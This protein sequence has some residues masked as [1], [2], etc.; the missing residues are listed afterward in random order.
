MIIII[1]LGLGLLAGYIL[2]LREMETIMHLAI[3]LAVVSGISSIV[4]FVMAGT[5]PWLS[6]KQKRA[7]EEATKKDQE[8]KKINESRKEEAI[9]RMRK[10]N[11]KRADELYKNQVLPLE[12]ERES[13]RRNLASMD[14][15]SSDDM[16]L[17]TVDYLIKQ[18][19][20]R[21][22]NSLTEALHQYDAK[23]DQEERDR[24]QR[25]KEWM[26]YENERLQRQLDQQ[27]A[28][29][30]YAEELNRQ[31]DHNWEMQ[32]LAKKQLKETEELRK[33]QEYFQRY[34]RP[35]SG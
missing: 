5:G 20:S 34:G 29:Q 28:N 35:R 26:Q 23:K 3:A 10:A 30:R 8:N 22:A 15:L 6:G 19:E 17:E 31:I 24:K 9:K 11:K 12:Q 18:L 32:R 7:I 4:F 1:I 16:N 13:H 25:E 33:D 21:R 27:L 2:G 14:I